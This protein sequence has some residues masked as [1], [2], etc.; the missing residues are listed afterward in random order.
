MND[1]TRIALHGA[2]RSG[3]TWLGELLNSA[4]DVVYR[5]QPLFSYAFKDY[6]T[7]ASSREDIQTFFEDI[8]ETDDPFVC[9][10]AA[11]EAGHLPTFVKSE[12]SHVMYKEVRYHRLPSA[13]LRKTDDIRLIFLV[14]D[15][16][17][18]ISSWLRAPRE[19]RHDLGWDVAREWR[20]APAKNANKPEEFYGYE[21]WK[22][23]ALIFQDL[24]DRY[25]DRVRLVRYGT[26]LSD[27]VGTTAALFDFCGI[28]FSEQS[29]AF[30]AG[31]FTGKSQSD[32]SVF[33]DKSAGDTGWKSHLPA[34]IAAAIETDLTGT[35]LA[36]FLDENQ[37]RET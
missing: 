6:L 11:R 9:Q 1:F 14:R 5:Y 20:Y 29:R 19:F 3:T 16:R 36:G 10:T 26:L 32:Y 2:P 23:S 30:A 33:R 18:V 34:E 8:A 37:G 28:P 22:E 12:A 35:A 31:E 27:P 17:A 21:R 13:L 7:P 24:A 15:P 25:P 4:P